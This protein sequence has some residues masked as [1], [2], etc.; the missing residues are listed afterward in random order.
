MNKHWVVKIFGVLLFV[1]IV[2]VG[3]GQAVLQLWN[4]LMPNIFGLNRIS[5]WQAVGLLGLSWILFGG[6]RGGRFFG[7][8][9]R[10]MMRERW[11]KMSPEQRERFRK[12]LQTRCGKSETRASETES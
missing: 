10:Y 3:F 1:T 2:I 5:F 11:E 7:H 6:F 9:G 4:W 12:G 8:R